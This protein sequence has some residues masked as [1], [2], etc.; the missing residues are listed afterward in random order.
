MSP[1]KT[2][3]Y[4]G[5]A[6]GAGI[7]YGYLWIIKQWALEFT[8]G[9]GMARFEYDTNYPSGEGFQ[10]GKGKKNYFGPTKGAGSLFILSDSTNISKAYLRK[11][12]I[13]TETW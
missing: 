1:L 2:K 7:S 5:T 3:R 12:I 11:L 10:V 4:Q 13:S 9:L 6:Y 8:A